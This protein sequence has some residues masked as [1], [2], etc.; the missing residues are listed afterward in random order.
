MNILHTEC[1]MNWGGQESRTVL[2]VN[3]LNNNKHKSW[4]LCHPKSQLYKKGKALGANVVAMDLTCLWRVDIAI[5]I[6]L[7]C[8][9]NNIEIINT[10]GSKDSTLCLVSYFF[11][12]PFIR[13]MKYLQKVFL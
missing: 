8:L 11:G 1:S 13:Y 4:L 6:W 3:Y 5:R 10:H 2:E 12:I 9:K 7:F